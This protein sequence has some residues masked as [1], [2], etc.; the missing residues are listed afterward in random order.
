MKFIEMIRLR[1]AGEADRIQA[2]NVCQQ[3]IRSNSHEQPL[4]SSLLTN[5][6]LD[7]DLCVFI[8]WNR[9]HAGHRESLLDIYVFPG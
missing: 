1:A 8:C 3:I 4:Y 7:T 9:P 5:T 2:M 6:M